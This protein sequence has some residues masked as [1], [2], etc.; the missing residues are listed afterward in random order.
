MQFGAWNLQWYLI[1]YNL[2]S[3]TEKKIYI[4]PNS[5]NI[6]KRRNDVLERSFSVII[7]TRN[8]TKYYEY[9]KSNVLTVL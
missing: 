5:C 7:Y 8:I 3:T 2:L 6:I 9:Y 1:A 4:V